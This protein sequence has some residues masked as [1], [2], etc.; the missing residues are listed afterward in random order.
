MYTLTQTPHGTAWRHM[1]I[2]VGEPDILLL[3]EPDELLHCV[4]KRITNGG[5]DNTDQIF[6]LTVDLHY[7]TDREATPNKSPNFYES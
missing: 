6:G 4:L 1:I 7:E 3:L 2:E 5:V